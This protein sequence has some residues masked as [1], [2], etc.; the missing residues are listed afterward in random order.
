SMTMGGPSVDVNPPVP[1]LPPVPP[2][3]G[4][5][6]CPPFTLQAP[7]AAQTAASCH[8]ARPK[9]TLPRTDPRGSSKYV[10]IRRR[11]VQIEPGRATRPRIVRRD[12]TRVMR[13]NAEPEPETKTLRPQAAPAS[14]GKPGFPHKIDR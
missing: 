1:V 13:E 5:V 3:S 11:C 10:S 6:P 2:L 14:P 7:S 8:H 12:A 9:V 4:C